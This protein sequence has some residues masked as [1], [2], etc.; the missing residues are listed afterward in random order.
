[1]DTPRLRILFLCTG[2]SCRSQ[3]AE[4]FARAL[5]ADAVET[6]S[7]G[8]ER[9]GM[10]PLAVKAMAEAGIDISAQA[11]KTLD[12]LPS[13]DFDYVITLCDH[14]HGHCPR[15]PGGATVVHRGF[16]DPPRLAADAADEEEALDHYRRVR[17]MIREFVLGLPGSL[18]P[19]RTD[20]DAG[21]RL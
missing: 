8:V 5:R 17:D 21:A 1:M 9:H 4:G 14:A 2:N 20:P 19:R 16:P 15:F 6:F 18:P 13:L 7:A 12:D 10:N 11:S 3:M